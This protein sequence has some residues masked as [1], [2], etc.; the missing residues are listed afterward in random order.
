MENKE[1]RD[2][3]TSYRSILPHEPLHDLDKY[4]T[5]G[6]IHLQGRFEPKQNNDKKEENET[7][8]KELEYFWSTPEKLQQALVQ[9]LQQHYASSALQLPYPVQSV[10][11]LDISSPPY[12]K[13]RLQ[14][15]TPQQAY[16]IQYTMRAIRQISPQHLFSHIHQDDRMFGSHPCQVTM[17]TAKPII[18]STWPRSNPP[19]F[20]RL[21]HD[22]NDVIERSKT[23][24][25][26]ITGLVDTSNNG[27]TF[28]KNN[29]WGVMVAIR[30]VFG[31]DNELFISKKQQNEDTYVN[32]CHI[33][34]STP[35]EAQSA[36]QKY[37]G[38][39]VQWT[40]EEETIQSGS[41]FLDYVTVTQKSKAKHRAYQ[42]DSDTIAR[43]EPSRPECTSTTDDVTI[44]GLLVI[45][46]YVT[47][48]QE[49]ILMAV[50]TGPQAPWAPD[51]INKSQTGV[52][53]RKVQH[54]GYVFD[55]KTADVLRDRTTVSGGNCPPLPAV[56]V[57]DT[58][59]LSANSDDDDDDD[60]DDDSNNNTS[61][62]YDSVINNLVEEGKGWDVLACLIEKTRHYKFHCSGDRTDER[63]G[64]TLTFPNINQLTINQY[65]PGEGIGSHVDTPSAFG[66]GLISIS[67]NSG[68][69]MEFR[70]VPSAEGSAEN[71]AEPIKKL[72]YLPPRSLVLMSGPAR[73]EWEHQIV[74]RRT[75]THRGVVLPRGRR[76]SLTL[77]T[78]L[79]LEGKPLSRVETNQFP[80]TWAVDEEDDSTAKNALATPATE[81]DHVHAVYD[82]IATQ[83]SG[84]FFIS[85]VSFA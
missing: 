25:V 4:D 45:E 64:N 38:M 13:I 69:V 17:I 9:A 14:Y 82:A 19:K 65:R 42:N 2:H 55:Y 43:G 35:E 7:T 79:D 66:D 68:I 46:D 83:V 34:F 53:K 31:Q 63:K 73:Y 3:P 6:Y 26:Y 16:E 40:Y 33:G 29:P 36:V 56:A 5:C 60:D 18:P 84:L 30:S 37:Q 70:K 74:T 39:T 75:D 41:L 59:M 32:T 54:Y 48:E 11:I 76:I 85:L 51:Q 15:P 22:R 1:K 72:V 44:Q 67:L 77:R 10:E 21:L 57:T 81:R 71:T 49:N 61:M 52:V 47:T 28:W 78:A 23:R 62:K 24:F 27:Q 80:P 50:L 58:V 20:R 8:E 12:T